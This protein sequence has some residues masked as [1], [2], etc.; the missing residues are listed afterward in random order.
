VGQ[1]DDRRLL[2]RLPLHLQNLPPKLL[3]AALVKFL[4]GRREHRVLLPVHVPLH[5]IF[6]LVDFLQPVTL[7]GAHLRDFLQYRLNSCVFFERLFYK[8]LCA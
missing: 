3:G 6:K 4:A 7:I 5:H 1:G 8:F 2:P